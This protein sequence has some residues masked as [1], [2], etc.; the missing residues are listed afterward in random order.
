M[1]R[2]C[3]TKI[4]LLL[5]VACVV[6]YAQSD[7]GSIT[8]FVKDPSGSTVPNATVTVQNEAT[9]TE[10]KTLTNDAG[11]FTVTNV[12]AG[13]YTVSVAAPGFKKFDATH[14]KLDPNA[15][16]TVDANLTVGAA[17]ETV[18]VV[19]TAAPLQSESAVGPEAGDPATD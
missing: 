4:M 6:L 16:A 5:A 2:S 9:G 10:R 14:N 1:H 8:G 3:F 15:V 18:E 17:T 19:A 11:Y 13:Y 7:L 12:P